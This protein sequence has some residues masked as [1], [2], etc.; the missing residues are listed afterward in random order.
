MTT[1]ASDCESYWGYKPPQF[2]ISFLMIAM[3]II[4]VWLSLWPITSAGSKVVVGVVMLT[5]LFGCRR[6]RRSVAWVAPGLFSPFFLAA[7][8]QRVPLDDFREY[9][10]QLPG[11]LLDCGYSFGSVWFNVFTVIGTLAVFFT[12]VMLGRVSSQLSRV[13]GVLALIFGGCNVLICWSI[14]PQ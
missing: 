5:F 9:L 13:A 10:W 14:A 1:E 3:A 8:A 7:G 2:D 12:L 11:I 4:A 6:T